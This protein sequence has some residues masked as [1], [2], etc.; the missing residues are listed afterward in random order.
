MMLI[1][2]LSPV[3]ENKILNKNLLKTQ[4]QLIIWKT[5]KNVFFISKQSPKINEEKGGVCDINFTVGSES[6]KKQNRDVWKFIVK[7]ML[8]MN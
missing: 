7:I 6:W 3:C 1:S 8:G 5:I 2:L 4:A